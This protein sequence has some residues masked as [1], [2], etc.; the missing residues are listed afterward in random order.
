[1]SSHWMVSISLLIMAGGVAMAIGGWIAFYRGDGGRTA[2]PTTTAGDRGQ[3]NLKKTSRNKRRSQL[4]Q[5]TDGENGWTWYGM[6]DGVA[7]GGWFLKLGILGALYWDA[8]R[9]CHQVI[10][11]SVI[12]WPLG[13]VGV[14]SW[15]CR[16]LLSSMVK[17]EMSRS[18]DSFAWMGY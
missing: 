10:R 12:P 4:T 7:N 6:I 15:S 8:E 11:S 17:L 16:T 2:S 14:R 9:S 1:M 18:V 3:K 5:L 13:N